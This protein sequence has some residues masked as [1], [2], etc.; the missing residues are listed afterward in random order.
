MDR[1]YQQTLIETLHSHNMSIRQ[2][3]EATG[4]GQTK[5]WRTV[6]SGVPDG[7]PDHVIGK[8]G[9]R[10][11]A[12][13]RDY[14]GE[15]DRRN[16]RQME[17]RRQEKLRDELRDQE[18]RIGERD[19]ARLER[20]AANAPEGKLNLPALRL[21]RE[22]REGLVKLATLVPEHRTRRSKSVVGGVV[23]FEPLGCP[24]PADAAG[25][26]EAPDGV[27][28]VHEEDKNPEV[29][30]LVKKALG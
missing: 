28:D 10:Y 5:V 15:Y 21:A 4:I 23:V 16:K 2:I 25:D 12:K 17:Q 29:R 27:V 18:R 30:R 11:D 14:A 22:V 8:D 9:K 6:K 19:A 7:T 3:A 20:A 1:D 26:A 13:Q 24:R